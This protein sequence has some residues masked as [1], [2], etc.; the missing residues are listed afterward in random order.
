MPTTR[1][2]KRS[3]SPRTIEIALP[4]T[5]ANLGPAFDS[6]AIALSLHLTIRAKASQ[7]F[8]ITASGRDTGVCESQENNLLLE[9]YRDVLTLN[10]KEVLPLTIEMRNGIPIGKGL[11]SSAAARLAGVTL[12]VHFGNL[13]WSGRAV[14]A[15]AV[16]REGHGDNA[17]ACWLGGL[18]LVN[19]MAGDPVLAPRSAAYRVKV[20]GKWPLL[21]AVPRTP[22]STQMARSVL[23]QTYSRPDCVANVQSALLLASA[24]TLGRADLLRDALDDRIHQPY[25]TALCPLLRPLQSLAGQD[26]IIG[27]VLSGAGPSVLL[28]LDPNK[29]PA[30]AGRRVGAFLEECSLPAE[31]IST[32]MESRGAAARSGF[33][34]QR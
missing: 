15:E 19:P 17:A 8:R 27:A 24:F 6:A 22:L 20:R 5:S 10:A 28:F 3:K 9:T 23:P 25:R 34:P 18:V 33:S 2:V 21:L 7:A 32:T 14:L 4:A 30:A 11:G 31:I 13:A 12:A 1:H 29:S 16:R 26:G